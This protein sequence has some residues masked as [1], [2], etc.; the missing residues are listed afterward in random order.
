MGWPIHTPF[1]FPGLFLPPGAEPC[2]SRERSSCSRGPPGPAAAAHLRD[3]QGSICTLFSQV[4]V[5]FTIQYTARQ[6]GE[7]NPNYCGYKTRAL[8]CISRSYFSFI[9]KATKIQEV[10]NRP[11]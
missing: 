7:P 5:A 9:K 4:F 2:S 3:S 10:T 1:T 8:I 6:A 11:T